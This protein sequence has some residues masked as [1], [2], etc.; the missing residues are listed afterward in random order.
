MESFL[1][2]VDYTLQIEQLSMVYH[3]YMEFNNSMWEE[4]IQACF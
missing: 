3:N 4:N 1:S 2:S